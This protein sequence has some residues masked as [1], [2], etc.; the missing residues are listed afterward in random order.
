MTTI[1][2]NIDIDVDRIL[3][4]PI[5]NAKYLVKLNFKKGVPIKSEIKGQDVPELGEFFKNLQSTYPT[6]YFLSQED[7]DLYD[8][9]VKKAKIAEKSLPVVQLGVNVVEGGKDASEIFDPSQ[10]NLTEEELSELSDVQLKQVAL[11]IGVPFA[12]N[13]LPETLLQKIL[14]FAN[15]VGSEE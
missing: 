14:D 6:R 13:I 1:I 11:I 10:V 3:T 15:K 7:Y 9:E 5:T 8:A 2:S 4:N 12:S